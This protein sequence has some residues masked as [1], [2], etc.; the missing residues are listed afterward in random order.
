MRPLTIFTTARTLRDY[1]PDFDVTLEELVTEDATNNGFTGKPFEWFDEQFFKNGIQLAALNYNE[2]G[3]TTSQ[4]NDFQ[5][6]LETCIN[7]A[8]FHYRRRKTFTNDAEEFKDHVKAWGIQNGLYYLT[9]F[10]ATYKQATNAAMPATDME[11][12]EEN[13]TRTGTNNSTSSIESESA[14]KEKANAFG[15]WDTTAEGF[16]DKM[17]SN[18]RN[19]QQSGNSTGTNNA[20]ANATE[21]RTY[22]R[23]HATSNGRTPIELQEEFVKRITNLSNEI[24][25]DYGQFFNGNLLVY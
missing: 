21:K 14:S 19:L 9:K 7:G 15:V 8:W 4:I 6:W 22:T 11:S 5:K 1:S 25:N 2:F 24:I 17:Q 12:F 18:G 3:F 16:D 23:E 20:T 10:V 13:V